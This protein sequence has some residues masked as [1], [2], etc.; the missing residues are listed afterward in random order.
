MKK[1]I[2]SML[3]IML[4]LIGCSSASEQRDEQG[5][6]T[7]SVNETS[8]E[9][10]N[11]GNGEQSQVTPEEVTLNVITPYGTPTLSMVKMIT[12]NPVIA[13]NVTVN[14]ETIEST[15][16][17]TTMLINQE[18]DIAVVPTN[19]AAVLYNKG[20][21][22][23]LAGTSVWGNFYIVSSEDISSLDDLKGKTISA[24]GRN[25][26]PDILLR[27]ILTKN[28]INPDEDVT[29]D[30]FSGAS[31]LATNYISGNSNLS[32]AAEPVLTSLLMK[33]QDSKVVIN[34]QE[35]WSKLTGFEN[36]PQASLIISENIIE[37]NPEVIQ[38]FVKE[39]K[40]S[41]NWI[42]NNPED[43][44]KYYESLGIGLKA[45]I[46]QKAIPGCNLNYLSADEVKES[47]E[48]Y[49]NVLYE[50]NPKLLGE[51]MVD[52]GLYIE[53]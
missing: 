37:S 3:I 24:F 43:A 11:E 5:D 6:T 20:A 40:E 42:N 13:E 39:Y 53:K 35:E 29:F 14:Y 38:A 19:M 47:I 17:L 31:E 18:A 28:G 23:K 46:V 21:G 30:Y 15:D 9:Q 36:Y 32:L 27:Y 7:Q 44:G 25:L 8:S 26:T 50:F 2:C 10:N 16:V 49:L 33:R 48:A 51:K 52:E 45:P 1:V 22:Y 34:L 12:E 4:L 41:I